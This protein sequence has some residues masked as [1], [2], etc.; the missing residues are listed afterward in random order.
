MST[1]R[2]IVLSTNPV[3]EGGLFKIAAGL[4]VEGKNELLIIRMT[5]ST[6]F[7]DKLEEEKAKEKQTK[8]MNTIADELTDMGVETTFELVFSSNIYQDFADQIK[9]IKTDLVL[10]QWGGEFDLEK[11]EES[12]IGRL[13][14]KIPNS[15][16]VIKNGRLG[17][18]N[19]VATLITEDLSWEL[20]FQ[21][22]LKLANFYQAELLVLATARAEE[23]LREKEKK[24]TALFNQKIKEAGYEGFNY[25]IELL[26]PKA[27]INTVTGVCLEK[28]ISLLI[29]GTDKGKK[30]KGVIWGP[31]IDNLLNQLESPALVTR[32]KK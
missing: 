19:K 1:N 26:S 8:E 18:I 24:L 9:E 21:Y 27:L 7:A 25:Q 4:A 3:A 6:T 15:V 10:M 30:H 5:S 2:I 14:E 22:S 13:I 12:P 20:A 23:S 17:R 29:L 28:E 11:R 31:V 16:G 32:D